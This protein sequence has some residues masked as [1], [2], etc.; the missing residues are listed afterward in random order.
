L[1]LFS[2]FIIFVIV[3]PTSFFD[4][5]FI[6]MGISDIEFQR[7]KALSQKMNIYSICIDAANAYMYSFLDMIKRMRNLLPDSIIMAGNVCTPEG[8]ENIIKAG[9]DIAKCGIANGGYCQTKNKTGINIPQFSVAKDCGQAANELNA[10][11]CSDGGCKDPEDVC[12]GLGA[13]SHLIM[14][15]S[16]FAGVNEA[17]ESVWKDNKMLMYGMS[18]TYANNNYF[19]GLKSY[20]TSEGKEEFIPCKGSIIDIVRDIKGG[21]TS[22]CTYT[23]TKNLENLSKNCSFIV[24]NYGR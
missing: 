6:S 1:F 13:G 15:G 4:K 18:S 2:F 17:I 16:M 24:Y 21:L 11:C 10:L 9:A 7:V 14:I 8:F 5:S 22:C 20:R 3:L 12:K 23:N 19:G